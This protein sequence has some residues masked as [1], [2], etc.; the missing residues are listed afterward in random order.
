MAGPSATGRR[1]SAP[2]QHPRQTGDRGDKWASTA[3]TWN[4]AGLTETI[5]AM[6][7][8]DDWLHFGLGLGMVALGTALKGNPH[9]RSA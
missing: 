4:H 8:A 9:A 5:R 1:R 7:D 2:D 6:P 3:G